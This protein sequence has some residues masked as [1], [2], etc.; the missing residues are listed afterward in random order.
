[1]L[2]QIW[3]HLGA[4]EVNT[5]GTTYM[6]GLRAACKAPCLD[7]TKLPDAKNLSNDEI[8]LRMDTTGVAAI[9]KQH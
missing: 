3:G 5:L 6:K 9:V 1:M 8:S 2:S 4:A 7:K